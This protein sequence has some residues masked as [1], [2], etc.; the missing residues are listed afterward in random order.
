MSI[1]YPEHSAVCPVQRGNL[2]DCECG[3]SEFLFH[4]KFHSGELEKCEFCR[5]A[6]NNWITEAA[7]WLKTELKPL[8]DEEIA[9]ANLK[10]VGGS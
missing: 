3:A 1:P 10:D 2:L 6:Q 7:E 8:V 5:P 4:K 9:K